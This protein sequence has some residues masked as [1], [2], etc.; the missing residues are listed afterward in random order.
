MLTVFTPTFN[1]YEQLKCLYHSLVRQQVEDFEWLV[2]DDGSTDCTNILLRELSE[3]APFPIHYEYQKNG[4]KHR[5]YNRALAMAKGEW[6]VCIDSDDRLADGIM[7]FLLSRL[8][9]EN[10]QIVVAYK[11]NEHGELLSDSFPE[12]GILT[13]WYSLQFEQRCRGEFTLVFRTDYARRYPFPT[14]QDER[15][16][17]ESVIYDRM[18]RDQVVSVLPEIVTVC[19]Y[20]PEGLSARTN[21]IMRDNPA[22]FCLYYMQRID[23]QSSF[24]ART[25]IAGKYWAFCLFAGQKRTPY[26]GEHPGVVRLAAPLGT[27]FWLY[28]K[29]F[30]F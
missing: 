19:E 8:Q 14:F 25:I 28:Y 23:L 2:I 18:A 27:V 20:Q 24:T 10:A 22:C 29:L 21:A 11:C 30:R 6:F 17:T 7:T 13:S 3:S 12:E 9:K 4:G 16:M 15:F 1:R 5:A 26:T